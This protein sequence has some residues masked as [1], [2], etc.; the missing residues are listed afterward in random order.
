MM[1]AVFLGGAFGSLLRWLCARVEGSLRSESERPVDGWG[2][3]AANII[4]CVVL[5]FPV[6]QEPGIGASSFLVAGL[7]GGLSTFSSFALELSGMWQDKRYKRAGVHL[8]ANV[9]LGALAFTLMLP[10]AGLFGI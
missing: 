8:A 6:A 9:V 1:L 3:T 10:I 2:T 5:A 4:A 7:C